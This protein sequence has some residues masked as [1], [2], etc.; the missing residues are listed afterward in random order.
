MS[1]RLYLLAAVLA[2]VP[3][4]LMADNVTLTL[5]SPGNNPSGYYY[6]TP[7]Q[8]TV[9]GSGQVLSL[10][11][12][13]FNHDVS[14][15]QTWNAVLQPLTSANVATTSQYGAPD[16]LNPLDSN[17]WQDY[18]TAAFLIDELI[19]APSAYWQ[20][21]YQYAAWEIFLPD[22]NSSSMI[23]ADTNAYQASVVKAEA[24]YGTGTT[25]AK[26]IASAYTAAT[27]A[28][29]S[30]YMPTGFDLVTSVPYGLANSVQE[31]LVKVPPVP[32]P[33]SIIL[34]LTA[35]FAAV[36]VARRKRASAGIR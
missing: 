1:R 30:G 36:L 6:V 26:D 7:Y 16:P 15:G 32:E 19:S 12:I 5:T 27:A 21:V 31:F 17:A 18:S 10:Y 35:G 13:D 22:G 11:C 3:F 34:L 9:Q 28:V 8:A 20:A 23:T 25:F 24:Q 2:T 14:V 33:S 4:S 29:Q